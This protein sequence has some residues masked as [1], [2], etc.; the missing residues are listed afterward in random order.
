[1]HPVCSKERSAVAALTIVGALATAATAQ[2]EL[3]EINVAGH[4]LHPGLESEF[5]PVG[6]FAAEAVGITVADVDGDGF[7]DVFVPDTEGHPNQLFMNQGDGTFA[8][9]AAELGVDEPGKRRGMASFFDYDEDGDLDLITVG[10]PGTLTTDL[11][12]FTLFRN[13][14]GAFTDVT[15]AAGGFALAPTTETTTK[16][17]PG[18]LAI[19]DYDGDG[20][21]D[22]IATFWNRNDLG[23]FADDQFRLFRSVANPD[24]D[25]LDPADS[26]RLFVDATLEA[27][28]DGLGGNGWIWMPSWHDFDRD[29]LVDLHINVER[30]EDLLLLNQ[31][32][33]TFSANVATAIGLNYNGPESPGGPWGHEMGK[34]VAD[35]DNDG[36]LDLYLTNPASGVEGKWDCFYRNDSDLRIG[37]GGLAFTNIGPLM[38]DVETTGVGWGAVFADLDVDGDLDLASARGMATLWSDSHVFENKLPLLAADG[39]SVLL[40]KEVGLGDFHVSSVHRALVAFDFDNDGDLDVM[41]TRSAL[42]DG[43]PSDYTAAFYLNTL[44][45]AGGWLEVDLVERGGSLDT[46]G[47]RMFVGVDDAVQMREVTNGGSFLCQEPARQHFGTGGAAEADWLVVRWV[48]G[49]QSVAT[50]GLAGLVTI[51]H[52]GTDA[53]GDLDGDGV[54]GCVDLELFTQALLDEASVDALVPDHPWRVLADADGNGLLDVRDFD[55]LRVRVA[56]PVCALAGAKSWAGGTP[57]LVGAGTLVEGEP[58]TADFDGVEPDA[59]LWLL[60]GSEPAMLPYKVGLLVPTPEVM[61]GPAPTGTGTFTIEVPWPPGLPS[62]FLL[63]VQG[64]IDGSGPPTATNGLS[65]LVP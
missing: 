4:P 17:E 41:T 22:V 43:A 26:P 50:S 3:D 11:D 14:G 1:M 20:F 53:T 8:E 24:F 6:E 5:H 18:G 36:D 38:T 13:D 7:L 37:G 31:G 54:V 58:F 34:A 2:Y 55:L 65:L 47:A 10:Y 63:L 42:G 51:A 35:Y 59:T 16:G 60:M 39:E 27:G 15:A 62:G 21:L 56:D 33:G 9:A 23:D 48:D 44:D 28:L 29:G 57:S 12:L 45:P 30:E 64:W 61:I 25:P 19:A 49:T 40:R 52:D 46:I 32:D